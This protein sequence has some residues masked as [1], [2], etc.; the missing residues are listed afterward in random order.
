MQ[1]D[2][3]ILIIAVAISVVLVMRFLPRW[4]AGVPFIEPMAVKRLMDDGK[5]LFVLDVRQRGDFPGPLGHLPGAVNVPLGDLWEKLEEIR[6]SLQGHLDGSIYIV[7]GG[8]D[9]SSNA[10]RLL[11]KAGFTNISIIKGGMKRWAREGLPVVGAKD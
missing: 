5:E 6:P 11:K 9:R 10:A 3:E 4:L 1:L 7:C 8:E 2:S